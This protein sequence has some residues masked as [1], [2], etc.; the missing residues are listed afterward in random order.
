MARWG[1][2]KQLG[3]MEKEESNTKRT[4]HEK[5][6]DYNFIEVAITGLVKAIFAIV[7]LPML[8]FMASLLMRRGRKYIR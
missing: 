4:K 8:P 3:L 5:V 6:T 2:Q 7:L 1:P